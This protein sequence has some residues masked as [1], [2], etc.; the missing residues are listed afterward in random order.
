MVNNSVIASEIVLQMLHTSKSE[1]DNQT[2]LFPDLTNFK[3]VALCRNDKDYGLQ[4]ELPTTSLVIE[5]WHSR[6]GFSSG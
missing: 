1:T 4:R 5:T 6:G 2:T 3:H